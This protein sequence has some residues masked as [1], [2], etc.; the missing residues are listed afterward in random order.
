ME[1]LDLTGIPSNL[2]VILGMIG[3]A[4]ICLLA[5]RLGARNT[6]EYADELNRQNAMAR[7]QFLKQMMVTFEMMREEHR[8]HLE[9]MRDSQNRNMAIIAQMFEVLNRSREKQPV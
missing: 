2:F 8:G 4:L 6:K 3:G 5:F 1:G 9:M 7:E